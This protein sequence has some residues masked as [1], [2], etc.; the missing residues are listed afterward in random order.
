MYRYSHICLALFTLALYYSSPRQIPCKCNILAEI[1]DSASER[2]KVLALEMK[3]S[4][5]MEACEK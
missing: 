3:R 2:E 1:N 4:G 5:N